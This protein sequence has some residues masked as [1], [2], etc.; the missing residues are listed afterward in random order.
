[1]SKKG[2]TFYSYIYV[3]PAVLLF[4]L[5]FMWPTLQGVMKSFTYWNATSA[6]FAGFD[7]Y[8]SIIADSKMNIVLK[9]TFIFTVVTTL[10]KMFFGMI[11]ALLLNRRAASTKI[12]RSVY[13]MPAI[14]S[15]ISVALIF[16][17]ILHPLGI[18]NG[19]LK[20]LH[21]NFLAMNWLTDTKLVM[22]SISAIEVWKWS[23]FTMTMLL[24]GLQTIPAEY[25]EAANLDG[26]SA[27]Q[28]FRH[29]QLP[30]IMPAFNNALIFSLIGGIKVF[31]IVYALTG[32]GPGSASE[33]LNSYVFKAYANGFYG[34]ACAAG[35]IIGLFVLVITLLMLNP[36]RK[37]EVEL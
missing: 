34:E 29:I 12:I 10:F 33:V 17:S 11:L 7:N 13:F 8:L 27:L 22:Y 28:K 15:N 5:F 36:L 32:G 35:T 3:I 25:Y 14:I 18:M 20:G 4:S 16:N 21:L 23:G 24:A 6:R 31:D 30:L 26:A 1:M 9:N 37:K 19:L 2:D